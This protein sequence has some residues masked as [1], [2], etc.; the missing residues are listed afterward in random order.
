MLL[1][2]AALPVFNGFYLHNEIHKRSFIKQNKWIEQAKRGINPIPK[3]NL[4][5]T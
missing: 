4:Q 1:S 2:D 3:T 5:I